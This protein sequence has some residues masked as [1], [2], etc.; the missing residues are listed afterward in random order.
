MVNYF[1]EKFRFELRGASIFF[2][3]DHEKQFYTVKLI[4]IGS[5][6][7]VGHIDEGFLFGLKNV[8]AMI[9]KLS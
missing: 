4:D 5:M 3:L 8:Y 1:A 9:S 7:Y 2:V 6:E